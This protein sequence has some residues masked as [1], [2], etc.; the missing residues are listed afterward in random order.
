M[1]TYLVIIKIMTNTLALITWASSGLGKDFA[2]IHAK[3]WWDVILVARRWDKLAEIKKDL[4]S[5]FGITAYVIQKDLTQISAWKELYDEVKKL[6]REVDYL[7]NNAGFGWIGR[8]DS[9]DVDKN[10]WMI[11]LNITV[12]TQLTGLFVKDF[13]KRDSGK[14]LNV[15]SVASLIT[16]P[17]QAVYCATKA[18]VTSFTNALY[19]ELK[20]TNVWVTALLP[21]STATEFGAHSGMDKTSLFDAPAKSMD[22]A[23][24]WYNGM[25]NNE[26]NVISGLSAFHKFLLFISKFFPITWRLAMV[27]NM[28]KEK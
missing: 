5:Q 9:Q 6:D 1:S 16:W 26:I 11:Q 18:Y 28:Q 13:V 17:N 7:I 14:I 2:Y 20:D 27:A 21:S 25:M 15:S 24:D 3:K 12:L 19:Y 10:L 8:F 4:E 23:L 22:V